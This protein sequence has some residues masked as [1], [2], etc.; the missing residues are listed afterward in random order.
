MGNNISG[1]TT[2]TA[3]AL[4][5]YVTNLKA[6]IVYEKTLGPGRFLKTVKGRH[7]NGPVVIKIFIKHDPGLSLRPF[8]RRL[9]SSNARH[10]TA[11]PT[12]TATRP[13]LKQIKQVL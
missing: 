3:D 1:A 5:S 13:S 7:T 9:K 6:D 8:R 4:D 2:R 10:L 12:F 11:Y